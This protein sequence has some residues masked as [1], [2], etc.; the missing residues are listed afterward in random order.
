MSTRAEGTYKMQ[1]WDENPIEEMKGG[2]KI[3]RVVVKKTFKGDIEGEGR[4]EYLMTYAEDGTAGFVGMELIIG[5]I[6]DRKG[7]FVLQH[8][9][10]FK[11]DGVSGK[12][13]VVVGSGTSDL[14]G[15][16]GS[17]EFSYG[18]LESYPMVLEY[19]FE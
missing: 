6:G 7:S 8:T 13:T 18:H 19:D 15:L 4:L 2:A 12:H 1:G 14:K 16:R 10:T 11:G 5:N 9:G 17:G 3:S